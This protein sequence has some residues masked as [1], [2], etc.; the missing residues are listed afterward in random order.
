MSKAT[1]STSWIIDYAPV[2]AGEKTI[3][4]ATENKFVDKNIEIN[5]DVAA[6]AMSVDSSSVGASS[7]VGILGT[8]SSTQPASGGYIKVEGEAV[9]EIA[10]AGWLDEGDTQ[11][12]TPADVYY[13]VVNATFEVDGPSVK[14]VT[15]GYV[16]AATTLFLLF[17]TV[18]SPSPVAK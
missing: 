10:T 3:T 7:N 15:E 12:V 5:V 6:G 16:A 1:E 14:S 8:A 2:A 13:P 17:R 4:L 18:L 11:A 9:V